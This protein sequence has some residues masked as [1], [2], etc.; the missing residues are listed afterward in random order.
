MERIETRTQLIDFICENISSYA[1]GLACHHSEGSVQVLG[2]FSRIHPTSKPGWIVVV[3]SCHERTWIIAVTAHDHEHIFKTWIIDSIP[4]R[5][6]VGQR[7]QATYSI[8]N[9]DNPIQSCRARE[10]IK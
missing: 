9:G 6:Y 3:T 1:I 4:W 2:G 7:G 10:A 5:Y 8:Y